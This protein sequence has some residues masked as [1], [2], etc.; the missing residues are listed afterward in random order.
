M[1][2]RLIIVLLVVAVIAA[3][4]WY[5][6]I[7]LRFPKVE[8]VSVDQKTKKIKFTFGGQ[9]HEFAYESA[10]G[11]IGMTTAKIRG[12]YLTLERPQPGTLNDNVYFK[13]WR[14]TKLVATPKTIR[15][16]P[17]AQAAGEFN[18]AAEATARATA[19]Q[20]GQPR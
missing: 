17:P 3:V 16:F 10:V 9:S 13:I 8:V 12:F 7:Y 14:G 1:S 11:G 15:I 2:K 5:M 20:Q 4:A 19:T 6:L 18:P